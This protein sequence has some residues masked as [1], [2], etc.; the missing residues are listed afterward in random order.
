[1][2]LV[3]SNSVFGRMSTQPAAH[4]PSRKLRVQFIVPSGFIRD[5]ARD[6]SYAVK[7]MAATIFCIHPTQ[8]RGGKF[9]PYSKSENEVCIEGTI[10]RQSGVGETPRRDG[11]EFFWEEDHVVAKI[12]P[13][14]ELSI[15][16]ALSTKEELDEAVRKINE[17]VASGAFLL[18]QFPNGTWHLWSK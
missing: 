8:V 12:H 4:D 3:E 5:R 1:M 16:P 15:I 9:R 14:S 18:A 13:E 17:A 6:C 11:I 7:V 2:S 10:D